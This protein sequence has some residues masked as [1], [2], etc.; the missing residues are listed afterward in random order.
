M[1]KCLR[2]FVLL[3]LLILS[4]IINFSQTTVISY[5]SISGYSAGTC[6]FNSGTA[7]INGYVHH[8]ITGGVDYTGSELRLNTDNIGGGAGFGINYQFSQNYRYT[9]IVKA[10]ASSTS[11]NFLWSTN[12][13]PKGPPS[14]CSPG[15][16]QI[17]TSTAD[18]QSSVTN[19]VQT[20][21]QDY[22]LI[23]NY[24]PSQSGVNYLLFTAYNTAAAIGTLLIQSVSIIANPCF[25]P[26]LTGVQPLGSRQFNLSY[27]PFNSP[28]TSPSNYHVIIYT[29]M[30]YNG[31]LLPLLQY[32]LYN[33]GT[34][35][36]INITVPPN[37][38][39]G[40]PYHT[41]F[42]LV[43]NCSSGDLS[44]YSNGLGTYYW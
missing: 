10:R 25:P 18:A 44:S 14:S 13:Y 43:S 21:Y 11:I 41:T 3:H 17:I 29:R 4:S 40:F 2:Q 26:T 22:M 12:L 16:P 42:Y 6:F 5:Q 1:R 7:T 35:N 33:V 8:G 27:T 37:I 23:E 24:T 36:P 30:Y 28:I 31:A 32:P 38:P 20:P 15:F 39:L 19:I 9:I 34:S